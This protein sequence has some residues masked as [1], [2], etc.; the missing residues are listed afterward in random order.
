MESRY[1]GGRSTA[2]PAMRLRSA[3]GALLTLEI[4]SLLVWPVQAEV[5]DPTIETAHPFYPGEEALQTVEP[6]VAR[7][8]A[9]QISPQ[10]KAIALS[11]SNPVV[12]CVT[13]LDIEAV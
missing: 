11:G 1:S 6:C 9:G 13:E 8:T 2:I 10:D 4:V 7:A 3:I 5:G 12:R